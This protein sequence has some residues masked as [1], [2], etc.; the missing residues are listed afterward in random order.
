MTT[1]GA[2]ISDELLIGRRKGLPCRAEERIM[3][4]IRRIF[5]LS[6]DFGPTNVIFRKCTNVRS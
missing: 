1:S 3:T 6:G 4:Y 2:R 5:T